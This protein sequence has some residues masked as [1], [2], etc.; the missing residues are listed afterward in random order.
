M[1]SARTATAYPGVIDEAVQGLPA[2]ALRPYIA[3]YCGYRQD[4]VPPTRHRGMP[5]PFLTLIFTLDD[6][7]TVETHPDPRQAPGRYDAL[8]GGLH[9]T[10]AL[11][12]HE[13]RQSG[14]QVALSPLGAR[15]LLRLPA[16]E[17]ANADLPADAV[18]GRLADEVRARL[19]E[20][21]DWHQRFAVLDRV[22][23]RYARPEAGVPP[24]VARAWELLLRSRG[25]VSAAELAKDVGWSGRHLAG[26]FHTEIGLSPKAAARVIR[27]DRAR[28]LLAVRACDRGDGGPTG[29]D[30]TARP[31]VSYGP[32]SANGL[33]ELAAD[34]GY[35]DQAHLAR[36][37]RALAGCAPSRWLAEE[38]RNVQA[39]AT[40]PAAVW[41][42]DEDSGA[43]RH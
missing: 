32:N 6:P 1:D 16:G 38:F 5:S 28:R 21:S 22:L 10:S 18:L 41:A 29:S 25:T 8:L 36:E 26:R 30:G 37:F 17:L 7:L 43:V 40:S 9:T 31:P 14:V 23:W 13:G 27:F 15:A 3:G 20:A 24:Q 4:G 35:F 12:A 19:L 39:C 33:A 2:P 34:C 11:I 42:S